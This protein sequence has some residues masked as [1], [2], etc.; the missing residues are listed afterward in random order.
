M[1]R[2]CG[3]QRVLTPACERGD[4]AR[5]FEYRE[6]LGDEVWRRSRRRRGG[7]RAPGVRSRRRRRCSTGGPRGSRPGDA[8]AAIACSSIWRRA[9]ERRGGG[10]ASPQRSGSCRSSSRPRSPRSAWARHYIVR[11][12]PP[13]RAGVIARRVMQVAQHNGCPV[14][15]CGRSTAPPRGGDSLQCLA[16][17]NGVNQKG[18]DPRRRRRQQGQCIR[19]LR[20]A[21]RGRRHHPARLSATRFAARA[22]PP[23]RAMSARRWLARCARGRGLRGR[24]QRAAGRRP[25]TARRRAARRSTRSSRSGCTRRRAAAPTASPDR[26]RRRGAEQ[27]RR[28]HGRGA[29]SFERA[30]L[31]WMVA[32]AYAPKTRGRAG[33][34]RIRRRAARRARRPPPSQ[35][36]QL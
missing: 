32:E 5:L 16:L 24:P 27:S 22:L 10:L 20:R 21:A 4:I 33:D 35:L 17:V 13:P 30:V 7:G 2:R 36:E 11:N 8:R 23:G 25:R 6:L 14:Y 1:A 18:T 34:R 12:P 15:Q 29:G 19:R 31:M 3:P 26:R 9:G 28:R